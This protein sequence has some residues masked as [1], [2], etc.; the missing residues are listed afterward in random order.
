MSCI[1]MVPS[2]STEMD[3]RARESGQS[4]LAWQLKQTTSVRELNRQQHDHLWQQQQQ[5]WKSREVTHHDLIIRAELQCGV[6]V[7]GGTYVLAPIRVFHRLQLPDTRHVG[8]PLLNFGHVE[9][10]HADHKQPSVSYCGAD[11]TLHH[12]DGTTWFHGASLGGLL[13]AI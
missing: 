11:S 2:P 13:R 12:G 6:S 5:W 7:D 1:S 9:H 8:Q 3:D 10:L 4:S